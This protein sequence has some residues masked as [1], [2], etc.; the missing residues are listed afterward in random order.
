MKSL[1]GA[2]KVLLQSQ[3]IR[4][5]DTIPSVSL[6]DMFLKARE[7]ERKGK[8]IIHFDAGEPDFDPPKEVV[9]ATIR[10]LNKGK[11]RYTESGGIP[12]AKKAI[13]ESLNRKYRTGITP[14]QVLVTAGGR[15]ALYYSFMSLPATSKIGIISPD[16]PAYRDISKFL[17]RP[18][19]FF[20]SSLENRWEVNLEEIQNSDC[21]VLVLNYPTNPTGKILDLQTFDELV[22]IAKEKGMTILSDEV[23][24]DY[25]LNPSKTFKS[26]LEVPEAKSL[27]VTSLSKSYAMTG[28]RAAYIV[29]D[30]KTI[31][32]LTKLNSMI[33]TSMP[34][35]VQY[36]LI[37][38]L[39]CHEYVAEKVNLIRKRRDVA[40][41]SLKKYL[42]AEFYLSDGS[43]Y[44]FPKLHS[45]RG[46]FNS[47]K[48]AVE[49]LEKYGVSVTPGTSFGSSFLDH[50]RITLLQSDARIE[51][52]IERMSKLLS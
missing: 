30:P 31:S 44:M 17:S 37:A 3:A 9:D 52:G 42:N 39:E 22:Q 5:E 2:I 14:D 23:Y 45:S 19:Q 21:T 35:F 12:E 1:A 13:A 20:K 8:D 43:L 28:F 38:A 49:L 26:I 7:L 15:L 11:A 32:H 48:F 29:S 46:P 41:K 50:I 24:S 4:E 51:E 27:M 34:E 10:A 6:V 33:L 25:I 16:W 36:A 18:I 47:E 40:A